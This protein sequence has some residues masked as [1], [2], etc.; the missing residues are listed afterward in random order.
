MVSVKNKYNRKKLNKQ[1][2]LLHFVELQDDKRL[3][4]CN[5]KILKNSN[6]T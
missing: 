3:K 6:N 2:N 4:L 1:K 5:F